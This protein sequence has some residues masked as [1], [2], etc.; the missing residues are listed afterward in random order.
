VQYFTLTQGFNFVVTWTN[1]GFHMFT[2][3]H[4][5]INESMK[6]STETCA[7]TFENLLKNNNVL[8]KNINKNYQYEFRLQTSENN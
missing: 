5:R 4:L 8:L 1:K 2:R 7:G 3:H 6:N